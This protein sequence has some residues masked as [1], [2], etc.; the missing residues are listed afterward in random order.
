MHN[1]L[2]EIEFLFNEGHK[3]D[4]IKST[5]PPDELNCSNIGIDVVLNPMIVSL[6]RK[7][8]KANIKGRRNFK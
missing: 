7:V 2:K 1:N 6:T 8:G 4:R 3:Y 5:S